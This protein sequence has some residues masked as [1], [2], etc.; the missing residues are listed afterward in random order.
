MNLQ[1]LG[2]FFFK[3]KEKNDLGCLASTQCGGFTRAK[4][5]K[6]KCRCAFYNF[7]N[8]D[9]VMFKQQ[10]SFKVKNVCLREV[11]HFFS[12]LKV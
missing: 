1:M 5:L 3:E 11:T 12:F 6:K 9:I 7:I 8:N 4:Q 2:Y 10:L